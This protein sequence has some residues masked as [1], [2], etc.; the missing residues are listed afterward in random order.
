MPN[1]ELGCILQQRPA[2]SALFVV[3]DAEDSVFTQLWAETAPEYHRRAIKAHKTLAGFSAPGTA[4]SQSVIRAKI[5]KSVLKQHHLADWILSILCYKNMT[6]NV[7]AR[8]HRRVHDV[9]N[10]HQDPSGQYIE[11]KS[12]CYEFYPAK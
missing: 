9:L 1:G 3:L 12:V 4:K 7:D 6:K 8:L 5:P 10:R 11:C 2:P